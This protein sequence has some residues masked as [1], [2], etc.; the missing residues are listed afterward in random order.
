MS[1]PGKITADEEGG[2]KPHVG[3]R[4]PWLFADIG[5]NLASDGRHLCYPRINQAV[6]RPERRKG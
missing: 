3:R 4:M 5:K 6:D 1:E 2:A